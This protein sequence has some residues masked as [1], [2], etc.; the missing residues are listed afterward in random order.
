MNLLVEPPEEDGPKPPNEAGDDGEGVQDQPTV[1]APG[2]NNPGSQGISSQ[3][4]SRI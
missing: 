1:L 3:I 2:S 4:E